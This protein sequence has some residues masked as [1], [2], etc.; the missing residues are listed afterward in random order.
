MMQE[1]K[2]KEIYIFRHLSYGSTLLHL[3]GK[4]VYHK[5]MKSHSIYFYSCLHEGSQL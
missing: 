5:C 1:K 4:A 2:K 3:F